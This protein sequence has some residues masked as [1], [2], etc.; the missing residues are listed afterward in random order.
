MRVLWEQQSRRDGLHLCGMAAW[1]EE[2][3]TLGSPIGAEDFIRS[4]L[5]ALESR[6]RTKR[7]ALKKLPQELGPE[8]NGVQLAT[9]LARTTIPSAVA[10]AQ[11]AV[12]PQL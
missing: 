9:I 2:D 4:H 3:D 10:H 12:P 5:D 8:S 1:N 7:Q 6:I 11:R